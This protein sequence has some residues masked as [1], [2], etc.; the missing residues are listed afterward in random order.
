GRAPGARFTR[1]GH[2]DRRRPSAKLSFR[3]RPHDQVKI[4]GFRI[5]P[6][7]IESVLARD[8][9]VREVAVVVREDAPGDKR[10]IAYVVPHEGRTVD[11]ASARRSAGEVLP[12]YMVPAAVVVLD[13]LPLTPNGK[14]DRRALPAARFTGAGA[15]RA[16]RSPREEIL[17]GLFADVTG[18]P[19]VRIDDN[20]FDLGGHSLLATRLVA[21]IRPA[22]GVELTVRDV[23]GAPT[24]AELARRLDEV[25]GSPRPPVA[26]T[27]RPERVPLS[28]A[29][30]RLWFLS[31]MEGRSATYNMPAVLRLSGELD[32]AALAAALG[33][34]S[35]RHE[36]LRTVFR[37]FD[38]VPFQRVLDVR[39]ELLCTDAT[40]DGLAAEI[41]EFCGREFDLAVEPPL[42]ARL[43]ALSP[44]EHVLA[45]VIH[46]IA[47]DGWSMAPLADDLAV[48]YEARCAG[49]ES[50][51]A[52]LPV[53]YADYTLWQHRLF[54]VE[55]DSDSL[56]NGQIHYWSAA[57]A[58]LPDELPLPVDRQRPAV[59][60]YRGSTIPFEIG[61]SL[62]ARLTELARQSDASL[63][64]VVQAGLS[65]LLSRLGAGTDIP[66][67][68]A[69][70]GRT[71]ENLDDL[72]GFFVNTLVLRTDLSGDPSMREVIARV[73]ET[74]LSAYANQDLPF[75][76][77]VEILNPSRS[78]S[79]HPLFQVMLA[80]QNL[81]D[82]EFRLPGLAVEAE[83]L[84]T[85]T[86]KFDLAFSVFESF[87]EQGAPSGLTGVVEF[88][89]ELFDPATVD[90]M[91][92]RLVQVF[93]TMVANPEAR[94]GE[95]DLLDPAERQLVLHEWNDTD[96]DIA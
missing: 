53:Q 95:I 6:G 43:F 38:G 39:P 59:S 22:F 37:E 82:V 57:L 11:P 12:R 49:L 81:A 80:F 87:D 89:V 76:R 65:A 96:R 88:A 52:E 54:G 15:S 69:I 4:R 30:R 50:G 85:E 35:D 25:G 9:A 58:G 20:F 21:R 68:S 66:I 3:A 86:A 44:T 31:Q 17:C 47:G 83:Q 28:F 32:R 92:S 63:F 24:V 26:R 34:V 29:Q 73:R 18:A 16:P 33:D 77:L 2:R 36:A 75:E 62:H 55:D 78:A 93:E 14:L 41:A 42:R 13:R 8:E 1:P 74:D 70:A 45:L 79:R 51:A 94:L 40:P 19:K 7:E 91:L 71:D 72:V 10:L 60:S 23:F 27:T 61:A 90:R 46:H 84:Y 64:M 48:A 5:E 67:G 56:I